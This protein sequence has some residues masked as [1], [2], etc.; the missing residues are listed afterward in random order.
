MI[1]NGPYVLLVTES[2]SLHGDLVEKQ[3]ISKKAFYYR[4]NV[5]RFLQDYSL[6]WDSSGSGFL[7]EKKTERAIELHAIG[8][9]WWFDFPDPS[10]RGLRIKRDFTE[11][12]KYETRNGLLWVLTALDAWYMSRPEAIDAASLKI[13]QL[14]TAS[15]LGFSIPPSIITNLPDAV[16]KF[17]SDNQPLL[18]KTIAP[19]SRERSRKS[20]GIL[21][22]VVDNQMLQNEGATIAVKLNLFQR[23]IKKVYDIRVTVVE[24]LVFAT[25]IESQNNSNTSVDWRRYDIPNT[26]H[27]DYDLPRVVADQC[28]NLVKELGLSYGAIDLV[29]AEDGEF[30]FLEINPVGLWGWLEGLTGVRISEA[31]ADT[32]IKHSVYS[33]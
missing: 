25:K 28:R 23:F 26:P 12:V 30:F 3:L 33:V 32:L 1:N 29:R 20:R 11:W 21:A 27:S 16:I 22:T 9:V 19:L 10:V 14:R 5:D 7:S 24:D 15:R 4:L 31:I 18:F 2:H 13:T 6:V 17:S 8:A